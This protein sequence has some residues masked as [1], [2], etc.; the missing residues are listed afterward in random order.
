MDDEQLRAA[1]GSQTRPGVTPTA[2]IR[3]FDFYRLSP[4][5][6]LILDWQKI[7]ASDE[8]AALRHADSLGGEPPME[9][10]HEGVLVRRWDRPATARK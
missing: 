6:G 4:E 8:E 10:W 1:P 2:A 7:E 3:R 5:S 9:L